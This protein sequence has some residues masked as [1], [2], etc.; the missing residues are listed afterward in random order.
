MEL[1]GKVAVITGGG[2]GLGRAA[3][4]L[5]ARE[6]AS[7][8][9]MSRTRSEVEEAAHGIGENALAVPGDVSRLPEVERTVARALQAFGGLDILMNNAAVLGPL[10]PVHEIEPPDWE[11]TFLIDLHAAQMFAHVAVPRMLE[12]GGGK[13]INVTSGLGEMVYSPFGAYSAA[14]GALNHLTLIMAAELGG[15]GIGV[16]AMDPGVMD[17]GMQAEVRAMG[18]DVLGEEVYGEFVS[19]KESGS[20][21]PPEKAAR[22]AVFLASSASD[23]LNGEVGT[24]RHYARMGYRPGG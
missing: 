13:I 15:L 8:V 20:L 21:D 17:T 6:G 22:L 19:M 11:E 23:H 16:N 14:K 5:M 18:P 9:L 24:E 2:R 10:A 3:A 7:V 12:R 1:Q 4:R